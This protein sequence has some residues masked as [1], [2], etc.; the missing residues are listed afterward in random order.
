MDETTVPVT[1]KTLVVDVSR[2]KFKDF[3]SLLKLSAVGSQITGEDVSLLIDVLDRCVVGG[4]DDIEVT[5]LSN[6]A[7]AVS[8]AIGEANSPKN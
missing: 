8:L 1:G 7:R 2:M 5:E 3:K 6:I 4:I